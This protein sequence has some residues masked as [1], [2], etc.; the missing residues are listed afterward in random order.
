VS[1]T[2]GRIATGAGI[3]PAMLELASVLAESDTL[4]I[5]YLVRH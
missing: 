4:L 3:D 2:A 5:R 1:G